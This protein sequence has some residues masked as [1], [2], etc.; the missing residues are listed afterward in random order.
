M[1]NGVQ[2]KL[3][4]AYLQG[5]NAQ[6][7]QGLKTLEGLLNAIKRVERGEENPGEEEPQGKVLYPGVPHNPAR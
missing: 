1:L 6:G 4:I 7:I 3:I 2:E 5:G